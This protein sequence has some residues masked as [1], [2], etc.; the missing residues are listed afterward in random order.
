M[1][2]FQ[3]VKDKLRVMYRVTLRRQDGEYRVNFRDGVEATA[4]YTNDLEDA[5]ATG[6]AMRER[7][8]HLRNKEST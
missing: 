2:R 8:G 1:T 3:E 6:V 7:A 4:Y 5:F